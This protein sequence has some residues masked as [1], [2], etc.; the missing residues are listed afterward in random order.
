MTGSPEEALRSRKTR[1]KS[2]EKKIVAG[3]KAEESAIQRGGLPCGGKSVFDSTEKGREQPCRGRGET[4]GLEG[5]EAL[6]SRL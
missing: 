1:W 3:L 5:G 4:R 2:R 6:S